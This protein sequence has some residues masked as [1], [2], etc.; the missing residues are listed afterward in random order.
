MTLQTCNI[1]NINNRSFFVLQG[2]KRAFHTPGTEKIEYSNVTYCVKSQSSGQLVAFNGANYVIISKTDVTYIIVTCCS[3]QKSSSL[4]AWINA[5]ANKLRERHSWHG[6]KEH[7]NT[8]T[9]TKNDL[10]IDL[11]NTWWSWCLQMRDRLQ[12]VL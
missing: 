7:N 4:A 12:T 2:I 9:T 11:K 1:I 10:N 5:V 3:R 6:S 8:T